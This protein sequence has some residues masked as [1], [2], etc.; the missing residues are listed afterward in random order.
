MFNVFLYL[1]VLNNDHND[2]FHHCGW[3][4]RR[5]RCVSSHMFL[6]FFLIFFTNSLCLKL[7]CST[8][9]H[10]THPMAFHLTLTHPNDYPNQSPRH[11]ESRQLQQQGVE[12]WRVS[13]PMCAFLWVTRHGH[14]VTNLMWRRLSPTH[15]RLF[16]SSHLESLRSVCFIL[17][18]L[19]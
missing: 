3:G 8:N 18:L 4:S 5:I 1:N 16:Y 15:T 17:F 6:F 11:V 19:Y 14:K 10:L 13:S 9:S 2:Y 7:E 12:M